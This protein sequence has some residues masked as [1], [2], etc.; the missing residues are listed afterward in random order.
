MS[1]RQ[2]SSHE[3]FVNTFGV[4]SASTIIIVFPLNAF[5]DEVSHN[6]VCNEIRMVK[7]KVTGDGE[8]SDDSDE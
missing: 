1:N 3:S 7:R 5:M 6:E 4:Y 2:F 8:E